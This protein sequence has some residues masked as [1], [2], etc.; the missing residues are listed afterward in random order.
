MGSQA[1][2]L[3][4]AIP[5]P[6]GVIKWNHDMKWLRRPEWVSA[7]LSLYLAMQV[8][9]AFVLF[10]VLVKGPAPTR[11]VGLGF[12]IGMATG[13]LVLT[14]CAIGIWKDRWWAYFLQLAIF[15]GA[16]IAFGALPS[17]PKPEPHQY[18]L[19]EVP[20]QHQITG[21]LEVICFVAVCW[22]LWKRGALKWKQ[23]RSPKSDCEHER[24]AAV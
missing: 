11:H 17:K 23:R 1:L 12:Q 10:F 2:S 13:I 24:R 6:T 18:G 21:W 20:Y 19:L 5:L 7:E 15:I 14:A 4:L 3:E 16:V 22:N 9:I 8:L